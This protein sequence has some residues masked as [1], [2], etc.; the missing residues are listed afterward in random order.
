MHE[1]SMLEAKGMQANALLASL[2]ETFSP[3]TPTPEDSI[4][5]IMYRAGQR[6]VIEWIYYYME[7]N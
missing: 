7:D 4:Q 5:T 1:L 2:E 3:K 6:S